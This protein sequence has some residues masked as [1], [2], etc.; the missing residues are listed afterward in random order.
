MQQWLEGL[1]I[2]K[3]WN[4]SHIEEL[5]KDNARVSKDLIGARNEILELRNSLGVAQSTLEVYEEILESTDDELLRKR[6]GSATQQVCARSLP[7]GEV[8]GSGDG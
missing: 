5:R 2:E 7:T 4:E 6:V 3:K 8:S 1:E